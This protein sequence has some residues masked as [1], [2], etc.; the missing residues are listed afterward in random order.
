MCRRGLCCGPCA[1]VQEVDAI[2]RQNEARY[3][4]V[5]IGFGPVCAA[6]WRS[7][8]PID[9]VTCGCL[10]CVQPWNLSTKPPQ[11]FDE[12]EMR[13]TRNVSIDAALLPPMIMLRA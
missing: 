11:R 1:N 4:G 3:P 10:T 2:I 9:C 8:K 12:S 5:K 7:P 6:P 13:A